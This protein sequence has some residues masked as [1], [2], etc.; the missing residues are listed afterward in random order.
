MGGENPTQTCIRKK[1]LL[2]LKD[3]VICLR[4]VLVNQ[5]FSALFTMMRQA[6]WND[7]KSC[8]TNSL[9]CFKAVSGMIVKENREDILCQDF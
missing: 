7:E 6:M 4:Q 1:I 2:F 9:Q 5:R 8:I 3:A